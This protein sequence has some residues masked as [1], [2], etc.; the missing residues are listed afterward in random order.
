M[1]RPRN[2]E[3]GAPPQGR[4]GGGD[5]GQGAMQDPALHIVEIGQTCPQV[6]QLLE[7]FMRLIS[8][9]SACLLALQSAK[10]AAQVPLQTPEPHVGTGMWLDEQTIPHELQLLGSA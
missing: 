5:F 1:P 8:Q 10:P 3:E 9:P 6:P 7:L 2:C 4:A